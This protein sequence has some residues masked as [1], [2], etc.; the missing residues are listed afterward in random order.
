MVIALPRQFS[1]FRLPGPRIGLGELVAI[2]VLLLGNAN[3]VVV[4]GP[5]FSEGTA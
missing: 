4:I 3:D 2:A 1:R 5:R